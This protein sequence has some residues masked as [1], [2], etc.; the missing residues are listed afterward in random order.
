M[1][2]TAFAPPAA[3]KDNAS[4]ITISTELVSF[5]VTVTD[6]QGCHVTGL[7]RRAFAVYEDNVRQELN[8]FSDRDA[9]ASVGVVF[10]VSGSMRG[11]KVIFAREALARFIQTSH[12]EDEY[13]LISFNDSARLLFD[14]TRDGEAL[15][16]QFGSVHP[17]GNTA[18][19]DGVAL[20]LEALAHGRYA[21]RALIVISDGE[22]NRSRSTFNQVRRKLQES[23]VTIYT[24]LI[25]SPPPHSNGGIVMGQ[26][27]AASGGKSFSPGDGEALSEAFE[28]IALELRHQYSLGYTPTNVTDDGQWRRLKIIVTPPAESP[29][30]IVRSRKGYY[31]AASLAERAESASGADIAAQPSAASAGRGSECCQCPCECCPAAIARDQQ[32]QVLRSEA[33]GC[34]C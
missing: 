29:R 8:F 9:P 30:L 11:E 5:T 21:K 18:L 24:I 22:D 23:G 19:Y 6:N 26:L 33:E 20:G 32:S 31:A 3:Q 10:D 27:A 7:D 16:A 2:A 1:K 12:P 17:Q 13:S 15:L 14:R 4:R 34:Q 25:G 28:Q